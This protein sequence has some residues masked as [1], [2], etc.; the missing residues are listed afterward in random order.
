MRSKLSTLLE[1]YGLLNE[2]ELKIISSYFKIK[3]IKKNAFLPEIGQDNAKIYYVNEG[4][5]SVFVN[6]G[7]ENET[8]LR[9]I[10]SDE[11]AIFAESFKF[12][13]ESKIA[14]KALVDST[15]LI[16]NKLDLEKLYTEIPNSN[17]LVRKLTQISLVNYESLIFLLKQKPNQKRY[18]L[19][20]KMFPN[21]AIKLSEKCKASF[22]NID[23]CEIS[24]IR[25]R[26]SIGLT[27]YPKD[28]FIV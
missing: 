17:I 16:I 10:G 26:I 27:Y 22:L 28:Y 20:E 4:I 23:P 24:R 8:I 1:S 2:S 19:F 12:S 13:N 25:K 15:V 18:E 7:T 6:Y 14:V 3:K 5:L 21:L 11:F 9:L